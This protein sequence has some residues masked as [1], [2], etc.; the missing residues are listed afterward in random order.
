MGTCLFCRG[1]FIATD[2]L[3]RFCRASCRK[4]YLDDQRAE[5]WPMELEL[6]RIRASVGPRDSLTTE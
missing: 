4:G 1:D 2:S 5:L 3:E 6:E